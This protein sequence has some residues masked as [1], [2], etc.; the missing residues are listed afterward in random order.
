MATGKRPFEQSGGNLIQKI[1]NQTP[2]SPLAHNRRISPPL[3]SIIDKAMDKDPD[4]RYQTARELLVDLKRQTSPTLAKSLALPR[5]R[6][7]WLASLWPITVLIIVGGAVLIAWL[8]G[9]VHRPVGSIRF[10]QLTNFTDATFW[11][12]LSPDGRI[13]AYVRRDPLIGGNGT[14]GA[15]Q[16]YVKML[17]DGEPVQLK[18]EFFKGPLAFSPEGTRIAYT[19]V[20]KGFSWDT[21]TVPVLGGQAQPSVAQNSARR[22]S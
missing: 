2:A 12:T 14:G 18:D 13:L 6:A 4:H 10:E 20:D 11:P 7:S 22:H 8:S 16:I 21:W 1:L 15:S 3:E 9:R 17:P 5:K 19:I